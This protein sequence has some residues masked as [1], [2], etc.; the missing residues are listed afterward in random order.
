M[1]PHEVEAEDRCI[2]LSPGAVET[3]DIGVCAVDEHAV[4]V[5]YGIGVI[6]PLCGIGVSGTLYGIGVDGALCGI[7]II[8]GLKVVEVL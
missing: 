1:D 6:G 8:G 2:V 5:L 7:D 3:G 4:T